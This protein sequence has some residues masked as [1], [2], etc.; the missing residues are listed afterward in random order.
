MEQH[1]LQNERW[2]RRQKELQTKV[3]EAND[4][5]SKIDAECL[6]LKS[7]L[8]GMQGRAAQHSREYGLLQ[9]KLQEA[10]ERAKESSNLAGVCG[11]LNAELAA[12]KTA[13][14]ALKEEAE[15]KAAELG[16]VEQE[17]G[18]LSTKLQEAEKNAAALERENGQRK[19]E[20]QHLRDK[21]KMHEE[22]EEE[23]AELKQQYQKV[24]AE[25]HTNSRRLREVE[26]VAAQQLV[27]FKQGYPCQ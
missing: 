6:N 9:A 20:C 8:T 1:R 11:Q 17:N 23:L 18:R 4:K 15:R 7:Q 16:A 5:C 21:V 12:M 3:K 14:Q 27:C 25:H 19:E 10:E 13:N 24:L 26:S 22:E 2:E